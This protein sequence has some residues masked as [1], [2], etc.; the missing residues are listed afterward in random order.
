MPN[1]LSSFDTGAATHVGMVRERN[2]DRYLVRPDA[3]IWTVA[4]G[5]GGHAAGDLASTTVID[6][7]ETIE[8]PTSASDLLARCEA[9]VIEANARLQEIGRRRGGIIVGTT[10]AVLLVYGTDYACVW[11]GDSRIYLIRS[12]KIEQLSRD[13]TYVEELI[14]E[15]SLDREE[16]QNWSKTN[17]VTRAIGVYDSPEM[18]MIDGIL[19]P[20]DAFV[21]CSDGLTAHVQ[22]HEILET[23]TANAC[24]RACDELIALTLQRGA[25]DNVT[26][27][28][29]RY[30]PADVASPSSQGP[31]AHA[32]EQSK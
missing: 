3:G 20:G 12:G 4:D 18:E 8:V 15:G 1:S 21:V 16:A 28:V 11:S 19:Q 27:V 17:V 29:A 23:V 7:L 10:V 6:A 14:G 13:H 5:M 2:E 9:R 25:V 31:T 22:D 26:V 24:Q 32:W 30:Q